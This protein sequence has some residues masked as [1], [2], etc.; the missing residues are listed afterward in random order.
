M[1]SHEGA[2]RLSFCQENSRPAASIL[3]MRVSVSLFPN[4]VCPTLFHHIFRLYACF[5]SI[6]RHFTLTPSGVSTGVSGQR[7]QPGRMFT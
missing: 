3:E 2:R 4:L 6:N 7:F 1:R 5:Q